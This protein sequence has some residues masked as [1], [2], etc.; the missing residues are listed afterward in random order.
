MTL[1]F[2]QV[3]IVVIYYSG[4]PAA[5]GGGELP[6]ETERIVVEEWCDFPE[7]YK[8]TKVR[9]DWIENG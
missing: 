8:M 9:E 6:P 1:S 2:H 3:N 4:A 7:L 5:G